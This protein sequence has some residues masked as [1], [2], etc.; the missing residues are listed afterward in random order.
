[1]AFKRDANGQLYFVMD[2]PFF[3]FQRVGWVQRKPFNYFVL[4]ASVAILVLALVLWP[5][6]ALVRRHY[7]RKLNLPPRERRLRIAVRL[8]CA[9]DLLFLGCLVAL[10]S[11]L[12]APGAANSH[13]DIWIHL[14]QSVG[15]IGAVGTIVAVY[16]AVHAWRATSLPVRA[17]VA[18][19]SAGGADA[20]STSAPAFP[21]TESSWIWNKIFPTLIAVA[22]IGITWFF[23]YWNLLNFNLNY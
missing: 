14:L 4:G 6:A 3:T 8:V 12:D 15:V 11:I 2:F 19:A 20:G 22:C 13:I 1:M 21:T 7:G 9:A 23:V 18:A 5:V 17:T 10:L 16:S